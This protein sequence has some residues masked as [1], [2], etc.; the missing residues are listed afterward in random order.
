M[1]RA[2]RV[3]VLNLTVKMSKIQAR[4]NLINDYWKKKLNKT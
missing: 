3:K 2:E 4:H 1:P